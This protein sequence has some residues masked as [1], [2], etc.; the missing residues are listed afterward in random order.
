MGQRGALSHYTH[1]SH[2]PGDKCGEE[3]GH[4]RDTDVHQRLH[5]WAGPLAVGVWLASFTVTSG[6]FPLAKLSAL[7]W[8]SSVLIAPL[9]CSRDEPSKGRL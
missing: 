6:A 9:G 1:P 2:W 5:V 8:L 3:I 7:Y 4:S